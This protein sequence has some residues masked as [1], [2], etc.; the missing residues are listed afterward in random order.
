MKQILLMIA[1]VVMVGCGTTSW[2]SDPSDRQNVIVEKAIRKEL[3]KSTGELTKADL[4]KLT[5]LSLLGTKITDA[6]VAKLRKAMPQCK[7]YHRSRRR[8]YPPSRSGQEGL[9]P[10]PPLLQ[11]PVNVP[12]RLSVS[13][14]PSP[15]SIY[16]RA[17]EA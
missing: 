6:G 8:T 12:N 4:A 3:G 2:V 15:N 14:L 5:R 10:L 16:T 17:G 11:R 9:T 13:T 7:I 1:V